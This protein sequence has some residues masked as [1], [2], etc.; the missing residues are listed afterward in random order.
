MA[1]MEPFKSYSQTLAMGWR[2]A[3]APNSDT[4]QANWGA[5]PG[6]G[7]VASELTPEAILEAIRARRVFNM[8]DEGAPMG[9]AMRV[10]GHWM[11]EV[12]PA[13]AQLDVEVTLYTPNSEG[14]IASLTL[15]DNGVPV[16]SV[17]PLPWEP[18]YTWQT[19]IPG[20]PGHFY[21]VEARIKVGE[22]TRLGSAAAIWTSDKRNVYL[23]LVMRD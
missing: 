20:A 11:G 7:I 4:H 23:P 14:R 6:T 5:W 18:L 10:N 17:V 3:L 2:V 16:D 22:W 21:Y 9:L 8:W 12:I 15:Y 13:T 19:T 1:L